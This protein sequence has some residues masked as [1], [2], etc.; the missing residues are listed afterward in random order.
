M[1]AEV[2]V[3]LLMGLLQRIIPTSTQKNTNVSRQLAAADERL[4]EGEQKNSRIVVFNH[5]LIFDCWCRCP[6]FWFCRNNC[7]QAFFV[8]LQSTTVFP[9]I[10]NQWQLCLKLHQC[11][12][13]PAHTHTHT[14][15]DDWL[16]K[17]PTGTLVHCSKSRLKWSLHYTHTSKESNKLKQHPPTALTASEKQILRDF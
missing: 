15:T 4:D 5:S 2:T 11:Q 9:K 7:R 16:V 1:I 12:C 6:L 17:S 8:S 3:L 10:D 14:Y 13:W